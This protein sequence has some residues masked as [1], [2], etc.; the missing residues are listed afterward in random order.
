MKRKYGLLFVVL[1][2]MG[3]L[4]PLDVSGQGC[5]PNC[6]VCS[7]GSTGKAMDGGSFLLTGMY[8][9]GGE[10]ET[11]VFKLRYGIF[12]WLDA[13]IGYTVKAEKLIWSLRVQA[14]SEDEDGWRPGLLV[15]TGSVQIGG[16][17]QSLYLMLS[18]SR[19]FSEA[20]AVRVSAGLATLMPDL[21][22]LYG[23]AGLT[24]TFSEKYSAFINYDGRTLHPGVSWVPL[25][26][27]TL[28]ALLIEGRDIAF[29][30]GI[31]WNLK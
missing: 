27:L 15:G 5:G 26:W 19:E 30:A 1:M 17:D 3:L 28:S 2:V 7:G 9:P 21:D 20:I 23:L 14:I 18:K 29:S 13:G 6:P 16:S 22:R 25:D 8:I 11:G 10:E 12:S 24:V 31:R 4:S